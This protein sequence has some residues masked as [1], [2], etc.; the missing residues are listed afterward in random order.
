MT[1]TKRYSY[2]C[3]QVQKLVFPPGGVLWR[4]GGFRDVH[5]AFFD[6]NMGKK[7]RVRGVVNM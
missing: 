7:I 6:Q 4:G 1:E 2:V 5:R 3:A